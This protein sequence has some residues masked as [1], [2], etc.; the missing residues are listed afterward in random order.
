MIHPCDGRTDR[1]TDRRAIAYSVLSMLSRAN[2]SHIYNLT[3]NETDWYVTDKMAPQL[4]SIQLYP[5][6]VNFICDR[7]MCFCSADGQP[8]LPRDW[9]KKR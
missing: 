5:D 4:I 1:E 7:G 6:F 9:M 3:I 8:R 2:K